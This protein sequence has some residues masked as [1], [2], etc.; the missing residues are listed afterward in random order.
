MFLLESV[1]GSLG[2]KLD[3]SGLSFKASFDLASGKFKDPH[4]S[5]NNTSSSLSVVHALHYHP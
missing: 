2:I 1:K 4:D 5:Q 3:S